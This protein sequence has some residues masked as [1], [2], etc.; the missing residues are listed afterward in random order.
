MLISSIA[1]YGLTAE[2]FVFVAADILARLIVIP[3]MD[4]V[5]YDS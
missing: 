5:D 1:G 3:K 2:H 4:T